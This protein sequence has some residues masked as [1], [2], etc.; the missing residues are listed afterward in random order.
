MATT[1]WEAPVSANL[2]VPIGVDSDSYIVSAGGI[3]RTGTVNKNLN[4]Y[5]EVPADQDTTTRW[6]RTLH[7]LFYLFGIEDELYADESSTP[8]EYSDV[9]ATVTFKDQTLS[10]DGGI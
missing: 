5:W 2:R 1:N 9:Q 7:N 4:G 3:G 10:T 6:G 8:S